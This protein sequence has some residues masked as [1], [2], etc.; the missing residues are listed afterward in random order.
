MNMRS[1]LVSLALVGLC[2]GGRAWAEVCEK[3][4]DL[5]VT[6]DKGKCVECGG[7][8][9]T[10]AFKLCV[11]C[12]EKLKQCERCRVAM[13]TKEEAGGG[14]VADLKDVRVNKDSNGKEVAL[15]IGQQLIIDIPGNP[16]TG[17]IWR[18]A[19]L[20]SAVLESAGD[21][22][23]QTRPHAPAMEGVGGTFTFTFRAKEAG[24]ATINLGYIRPWEKDV[25]PVQT[26]T[27]KAT[28]TAP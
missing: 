26:F 5:P 24:Q 16:T 15:K 25:P 20:E 2:A 9:R 3:C 14:K 22:K 11:K 28:V 8:T 6:L 7:E 12:A 27:L 17:Y 4:R 21:P 23:Y 18:A 1:V 13:A 19:K 10:S